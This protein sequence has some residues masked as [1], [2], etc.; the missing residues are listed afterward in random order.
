MRAGVLHQT[1]LESENGLTVLAARYA[2]KARDGARVIGRQMER[3][4]SFQRA[5]ADQQELSELV[6]LVRDALEV[7]V[8]KLT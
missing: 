8:K 4:P 6:G 3:S 7:A 2:S 1:F 5:I